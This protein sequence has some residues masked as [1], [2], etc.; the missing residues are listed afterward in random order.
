MDYGPMTPQSLWRLKRRLGTWLD[1]NSAGPVAA[2]D[3]FQSPSTRAKLRGL[4]R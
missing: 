3:W 1:R 2:R 4:G